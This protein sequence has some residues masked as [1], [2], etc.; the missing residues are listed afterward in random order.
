MEASVEIPPWPGDWVVDP[1]LETGLANG[2]QVLDQAELE[3]RD[4]DAVVVAVVK[5]GNGTADH[6]HHFDKIAAEVDN[7]GS[8]VEVLRQP[9]LREEIAGL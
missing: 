9:N 1:W 5:S 6:S 4:R 7:P 3:D 2:V 8:A